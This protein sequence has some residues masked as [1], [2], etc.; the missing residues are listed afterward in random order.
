MGLRLMTT[1]RPMEAA[2]LD[3]V[4]EIEAATYSQPWTRGVFDDELAAEHRTYLVAEHDGSIVGYG[5]LMVVGEDAHVTTLV[6]VKPAPT[7]AIGTRVM[8]ELISAGLSTGATQVTLEV[9]T[10]N[11]RAQ[12]FYRRF[13]LAPVG[14]RK[15]YYMDEDALIMWAHDIGGTEYQARLREIEESLP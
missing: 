3:A 12:D 15:N 7:R 9:R 1:I 6:A 13:G 14:V 5:G 11:R 10:S 8:L 2:D 4:M